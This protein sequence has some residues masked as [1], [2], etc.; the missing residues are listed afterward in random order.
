MRI[1]RFSLIKG[2]KKAK[3]SVVIIDV[4]RAFTTAAYVMANGAKFIIPVG[5]LEEAFEFKRQNPEWLL[6]GERE[7][8]K[9]EGFDYGNSPWE[10]SE[11]DFTGRTVIQTTSAGTQGIVNATGADEII[12][13]SFVT[14]NAIIE[15]LCRTRPEIISLVSMG[16][17][18][19]R[20]NAE[21]ELCASYIESSIVGGI[22]NFEEMKKRIRRAPSGA[23][24]FDPAQP[25]FR[26]SDFNM[27]LELDR[28]NFILK[29]EVNDGNWVV[30]R[31]T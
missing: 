13:G 16:D 27:A 25:H 21:D 14:A 3:G 19:L 15:H 6:I 9:V 18:G 1:D 29:A 10:V 5:S 20:P 17:A 24:F 23:K 22:T 11:V 12:L 4:F 30:K 8:E 28:F 2:A 26:E 7:G 31:P